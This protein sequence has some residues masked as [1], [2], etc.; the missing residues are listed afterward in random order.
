MSR[1]GRSCMCALLSALTL[2]AS[3]GLT[4]ATANAAPQAPAL[5]PGE[6]EPR[7][8]AALADLG[9][10][11]ELLVLVGAVSAPKAR[12]AITE[13]GGTPYRSFEKVGFSSAMLTRS[14]I[15]DVVD[16]PGVDYVQG[17]WAQL[18]VSETATEATRVQQ[19]EDLYA[20]K[21]GTE[22]TGAGV[23]VAI[24]DSGMAGDHVMFR[25][26]ADTGTR[27]LNIKQSC[28]VVTACSTHGQVEDSFFIDA[29][30]TDTD[31]LAT[32]G[33]GTHVAAIAGGAE[34]VT[35]LGDRARGVATESSL[36]GLGAGAAIFVLNASASVNWVL[37]HH[38]DPCGAFPTQP[39]VVGGCAPIKVVNMSFG[40]SCGTGESYCTT[41]E[42]NA[43][44]VYVRLSEA[45]VLEGVVPV[46]AA[47]NGAD[48]NDTD[49][50]PND[51]T[52][53]LT[54][55]AGQ[56]PLPGVLNVANYSDG[57]IGDRNGALNSS[58]SRGRRGF[59]ETYPDISAPGTSIL[60]AC[61]AWLPICSSGYGDPNYGAITG[62]SMAAPHVAGMVALMF[63]A[64]PDLTP[65]LIED[66]L[67]DT[68]HQFGEADEYEPDVAVD[69]AIPGGTRNGNH[70][71]HYARGH[72]L[73]DL[74]AAL[75]EV[76]GIEDPGFQGGTCPVVAYYDD[77]VGDATSVAGLANVPGE[78]SDPNFDITRIM[79]DLDSEAEVLRFIVEVDDLSAVSASAGE[80]IRFAFT[81][82][83][84]NGQMTMSRDADGL[85]PPEF[86]LLVVNGV[87]D[88]TLISGGLVG[89]FDDDA[90]R[91][92]AD[93]PLD[94]LV[95]NANITPTI[96]EPF[97]AGD[98]FQNVSVLLQ[99]QGGTSQTGGATLTADEATSGCPF[100][101]GAAPPPVVPEG[102]PLLFVLGGAGVLAGALWLSRRRQ[103]MAITAA[104]IVFAGL[105]AATAAPVGA[106]VST[107]V[108]FTDRDNSITL[109]VTVDEPNAE[110][111]CVD[112][113]TGEITDGPGCFQV[114]VSFD[115]D[116]GLPIQFLQ[117]TAAPTGDSGIASD[118]DVY[119]V[120][121]DNGD[122]LTSAAGAF[123]PVAG[124]PIEV[125]FRNV[126][127]DGN[128]IVVVSSYQNF[129]G[130][131]Y[132]L[133]ID[134]FAREPFV[135]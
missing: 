86:R 28:V 33:H 75:A 36:Y 124:S 111:S 107:P 87:A 93:L 17:N 101:L 103:A 6:L 113:A 29:T 100:V 1:L 48:I 116:D 84:F 16:T 65:A 20:E 121:A 91:V 83:S 117:V 61:R 30:G 53:S 21:T 77:A 12:E 32:G 94:A 15:L 24:V 42:Y 60:A 126:P 34:V 70:D 25:D 37:E 73:V 54:N 43:N 97:A 129:P 4:P 46:W 89:S 56:S 118:L 10:D 47:G 68:A 14:Q 130:A 76:A 95:D 40:G 35:E 133:T 120:D 58:S 9:A 119:I 128:F 64:E 82:G 105:A 51:G 85:S 79:V 98:E 106:E 102:S 38:A 44:D 114:P 52:E 27:L 8:E 39:A 2:V 45:L 18:P 71:T 41:N 78:A 99:R 67:E 96:T 115:A 23:G 109:Q 63:Q 26:A 131:T 57:N 122:V 104:L 55:N 50:P 112:S 49:P 132:D 69:G 110:Y 90:D 123:A 135:D 22:L 3:L 72:G 11:D 19:A 31:V 92:T 81:F 108:K 88:T 66:I 59:P 127:T 5:A 80:Y 13:A 134:G 7:L 125:A 74:T 62:T